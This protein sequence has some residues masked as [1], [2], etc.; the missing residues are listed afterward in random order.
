LLHRTL[1]ATAAGWFG[2]RG[3]RFVADVSAV[4]RWSDAKA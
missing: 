1:S 3:V 4:A 2:G